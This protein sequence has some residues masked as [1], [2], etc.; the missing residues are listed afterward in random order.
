M[1]GQVLNTLAEFLAK[2]ILT[3]RYI[4]FLMLHTIHSSLELLSKFKCLRDTLA[5]DICDQACENRAYLHLKFGLFFKIQLNITF[6]QLK[7]C[8]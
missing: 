4:G 1:C 6:T 7:L 2:E 3:A 5:R 8:Q